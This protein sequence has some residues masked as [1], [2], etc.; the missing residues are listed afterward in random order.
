MKAKKEKG[1]KSLIETIE[2]KNLCEVESLP[3]FEK[4]KKIKNSE[5]SERLMLKNKNSANVLSRERKKS[6]M[7]VDRI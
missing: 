2:E 6:E 3:M 1:I 5:N 7:A 4:E